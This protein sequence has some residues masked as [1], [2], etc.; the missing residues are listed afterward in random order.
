ML[1]GK[2]VG[3]YFSAHWCPPCKQF[4]PILKDFYEELAGE[5]FEVVFMSMDKSEQEL[6]K[7]MAELHGDWFHVPFDKQQLVQ[8]EAQKYGIAG[9]PALV[10]IKPDGTVIS[11]NGRADVEGKAPRAALRDWKRL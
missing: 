3:L 10:I 4:T 2:V 6:K 7:Y 11:K 5:G 9:I 8:A 1:A